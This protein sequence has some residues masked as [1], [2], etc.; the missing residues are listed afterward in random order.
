MK[1]LKVPL[2]PCACHHH[3]C[4]VHGGEQMQFADKLQGFPRESR[5]LSKSHLPLVPEAFWRKIVSGG[6]CLL[7]GTSDYGDA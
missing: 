1:S 3:P 2:L 4:E 7:N 6:S 5:D